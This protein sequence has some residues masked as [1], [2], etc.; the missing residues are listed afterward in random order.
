VEPMALVR[1]S[2]V[3]GAL[4]S[5]ALLAG[6]SPCNSDATRV[7][8]GSSV[9]VRGPASPNEPPRHGFGP[10][11]I[12]FWHYDPLRWSCAARA[13]ARFAID[14]GPRCR[15]PAKMLVPP[16]SG[17]F[18]RSDPEAH[19]ERGALCDLELDGGERFAGE[20]ETGILRMSQGSAALHAT[21]RDVRGVVM[22]LDLEGT[23]ASDER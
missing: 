12:T 9:Y 17:R 3:G 20:L 22:R 23:W 6:C 2:I 13:G 5:A 11:K 18:A 21:F 10:S 7:A 1:R 16:L 14:L 19:L 15:L 8:Y 4:S